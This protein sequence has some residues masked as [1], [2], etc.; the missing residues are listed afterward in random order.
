MFMTKRY[1]A[2]VPSVFLSIGDSVWARAWQYSSC[3]SE[4]CMIYM[5]INLN[6]HEQF[7]KC[8]IFSMGIDSASNLYISIILTSTNISVLYNCF[9]FM[10][11]ISCS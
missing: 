2:T 5:I 10:Q 6:Y 3:L 1:A 9:Y 4:V 7:S 11:F 8:Y